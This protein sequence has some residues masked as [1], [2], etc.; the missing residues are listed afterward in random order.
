MT[1]PVLKPNDLVRVRRCKGVAR[2]VK[3]VR[4]YGVYLLDRPM[5][6]EF[7]DNE[8]GFVVYVKYSTFL[9]KDLRKIERR[10]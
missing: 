1:Q 8:T 2:I 3:Y 4:K 6:V 5:A 7:I 9:K 10:L